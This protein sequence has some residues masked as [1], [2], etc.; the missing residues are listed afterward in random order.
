MSTITLTPRYGR[1]YKSIAE[2]TEAFNA[3][4]DFIVSDMSSP[5][6]TLAA[7]K[8]SLQDAGIATARIRYARLTKVTLI[9]VK[10]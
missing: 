3:G 9:E 6:D 5:W 2:V 7:N 1:D 10:A 4:K 8:E